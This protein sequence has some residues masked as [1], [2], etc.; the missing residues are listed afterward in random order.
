MAK[1]ILPASLK[2][3][4]P[5]VLALVL[6]LAF[7]GLA[8]NR[9]DLAD[10]SILTSIEYR[11]IDAKFRQRGELTPGSEV[12]IVAEDEKT[13]G[14]LGSARSL[15]RETMADLITHVSSGSP[16]AIGF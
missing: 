3:R 8:A 14:K 15:R 10:K 9:L 1:S 16:K 11:W 13:L 6:T 5:A 4:I 2:K 12:I 7:L